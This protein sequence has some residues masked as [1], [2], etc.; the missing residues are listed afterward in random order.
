LA[1]QLKRLARRVP[2][3]LARTG[4]SGHNSSGDIFLA[5]STANDAAFA[6][7]TSVRQM[8]FL[9]NSQ[10]DPL[11]EAVAQC[12]EEAIID[13]MLAN[14]T[15]TGIDGRTSVA[16]PHDRLIEVLRHAGIQIG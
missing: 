5:F 13:S 1:H 11:F 7:G 9:P 4:A 16:L 14:E 15:M 12:V 3:G 6:P 10:M 8:E 2:I